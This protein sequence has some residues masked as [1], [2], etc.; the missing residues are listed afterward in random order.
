MSLE[1]IVKRLQNF[2]YP[3]KEYSGSVLIEMESRDKAN[4]V[5]V[6]EIHAILQYKV[7]RVSI[8]QIDSWTIMVIVEGDDE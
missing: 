4:E 1:E 5:T 7:P 3:A 2:G 8:R 6:D